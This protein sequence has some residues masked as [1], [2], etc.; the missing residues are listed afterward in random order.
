[1]ARGNQRDKSREKNL[2]AQ[3]AL[4]KKNNQ[5]GTE[6]QRTKEEQAKIMQEKQAKD[7]M[8]H[9][10]SLKPLLPFAATFLLPRAYSYFR[11]AQTS[12]RTSPPPRSLP[13]KTSTGL[14]ILFFST[15]FFL[16][17]TIWDPL[18]SRE[19]VFKSS[20]TRLLASTDVI[21]NRLAAVRPLGTLTPED[22][23]LKEKFKT[24]AYAHP[25]PSPSPTL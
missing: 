23:I 8:E 20:D 5:S 9:I 15:L 14:N 21:F 22:L 2:K 1:M 17:C 7:T 25:P 19:N 6:F 18:A 3:G 4:K 13:P 12:I 10:K 11:A 16:A 24:R